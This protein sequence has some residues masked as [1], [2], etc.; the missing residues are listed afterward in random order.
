MALAHI[1]E[2]LNALSLRCSNLRSLTVNLGG[3]VEADLL[4]MLHTLP[5]LRHLDLRKVRPDEFLLRRIARCTQLETLRLVFYTA[6]HRV[7]IPNDFREPLR[8]VLEDLLG[9][10]ASALTRH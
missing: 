7:A 9:S 3:Y 1:A 2:G 8:P 5:H 10:A 4:R 6:E